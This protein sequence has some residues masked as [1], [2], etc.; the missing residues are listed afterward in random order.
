MLKQQIKVALTDSSKVIIELI[1]IN[2]NAPIISVISFSNPILEDAAPETVIAM[3]N[4]KDLDSGKNGE[5]KCSI[6]PNLPF[7]IQSS[8]S[9]FYSVTTGHY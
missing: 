1:D 3:L 8:A 5:V 4:V 7:K 6:A 2:D 9:N